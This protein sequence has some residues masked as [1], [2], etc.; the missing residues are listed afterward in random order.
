MNSQG[1]T[2]LQTILNSNSFN[3]PKPVLLIKK[4]TQYSTCY[5]P[6]AVIL[7]FFAGSGTTGHA[8]L[9]LNKQDDGNR[10][11][12][13]CTNN[14]NGIA[15]NVCYPRIK[16]VIT[17]NRSDGSKYSDGIPAEIRY[18]K[19]DF[20]EVPEFGDENN[21]AKRA[22]DSTR[23]VLAAQAT[24]MLKIRENT[25][26]RV[27]VDNRRK[28]PK[29]DIYTNAD[30][31]KYTVIIFDTALIEQAKKDIG[32]VTGN[33]ALPVKFY[34]FTLGDDLYE[35]DFDI[36]EHS[37]WNI[38]PIPERILNVYRKLFRKKRRNK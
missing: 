36:S 26:E 28:L 19:T 5:K 31:T 25:F 38:E 23:A 18:F 1:T 4:L 29:Y 3:N 35:E 24:E 30:K 15:E 12:I 27:G 33:V 8:V 32:N 7:D 20:I 17:G 11:F 9:E 16:T 37:N 34:L 2:E 21:R 6:S 13:L 22:T 14:E 10:Q